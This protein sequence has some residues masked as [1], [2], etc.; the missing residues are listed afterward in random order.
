[1]TI[2]KDGFVFGEAFCGLDG[3]AGV[4][5][6]EAGVVCSEDAGEAEAGGVE[7]AGAGVMEETA[8]RGFFNDLACLLYGQCTVSVPYR[9]FGY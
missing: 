4:E 8:E 3:E 9:G 1:M 7:P 6:A 5:A 2:G